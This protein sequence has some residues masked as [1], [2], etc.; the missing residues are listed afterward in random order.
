MRPPVYPRHPLDVDSQITMLAEQGLSFIDETEAAKALRHISLFRMRSYLKYFT[1]P[2]SGMFKEGSCFEQA[3]ELYTFDTALR[4]LIY[5]EL[6]K[7]EI[8]LR[9]QLSKVMTEADGPFWVENAD[10][11][12]DAA[13]HRD[14][15]QKVRHELNRSDE[16]DIINFR[17]QGS[18]IF[19][20]GWMT[21][22]ICSFG[23]ISILYCLLKA[24]RAK[25]DIARFYGMA[26]T[27]MESWLH[28]LVYIRNICA[29]H[30]LLWNRPLRINAAVPRHLNRPFIVRPDK[31]ENLY[32]VL[33]IILYFLQSVD[34][35]NTFAADV[36]AL[37]D[38]CHLVEP[39]SLG[40]PYGWQTELLWG[41]DFSQE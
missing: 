17:R 37:I 40:F 26:D 9:T 22:E 11:F 33:S 25:R 31:T 19:P 32:F 18:N 36:T 2:H 5:G 6:E 7:I 41:G 27:V 30:C 35:D 34:P 8:S 24:G 21:M 13:R 12:T 1:D 29:H 14:V 23:S 15:L 39:P 38:E 10:N 28:T 4:Q 20:P 16:R 3:L